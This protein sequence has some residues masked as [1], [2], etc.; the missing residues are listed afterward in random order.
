MAEDKQYINPDNPVYFSYAWANDEHPDIEEDVNNLCKLLEENHIYYKRDKD[1]LCPYRWSIQKSE[2]EIGEG[3][4][5]IVVIS[6]RYLKSLHCM[7][8][9]HLIRENGQIWK[10]VFPIVLGNLK[11]TD[12]DTFREYYKIF[13][14]RAQ[15]LIDQ[16][17]EDIIPLTRVETEAA[18]AG[19]YVN[20]L[21][22]MYQYLA[23]NNKLNQHELRKDNYAVIIGQLKDFLKETAPTITI[24]TPSVTP[25]DNSAKVFPVSIPD[26]LLPRDKEADKLYNGITENH[27]FNL[28]A[29]GGMGK[30][31]LAYLMVQR[32]KKD[33]NEIAYVVV[34]NNIK[35]AIV[36]QLNSALDLDF[37]DDK[38]K[39]Q[40][41]VT[42]LENNFKATQPNLLVLDINEISDET[43]DFIKNINKLSPKNW[44][45]LTL[46]R[47][48]LDTTEIMTTED[49]N[50]NQDIEFLKKLFLK[51]AGNRYEGFEK[52]PELFATIFYN[53]L[54]AEQLGFFLSKWPEPKSLEAIKEIL[55]ADTFKNKD[56]KGYAVL[57]NDNR[58]TVINFLTNLA[59]YDSFDHN[60]Q[61]LLRHFV[62]W[63]ADFIPYNVIK[64]LLQ[65]VFESDEILADTLSKL[66]DRSIFMVKSSEDGSFSYKLHGL[67]AESLRG[68]IDLSKENYPIY[69]LYVLDLLMN[70]NASDKGIIS[71]CIFNSARIWSEKM[72]ESDTY[73]GQYG[74]CMS[75]FMLAVEQE[76]NDAAKDNFK[77][78]IEIGE[79]LPKD[80][81]RY[82]DALAGAHFCFA[83]F[84]E[85]RLHDYDLAKENYEKA[86]AIREQLP[87]DNPEF[88][89]GLAG[90]YEYL[91][92]L[93]E[94]HFQDYD[95]AKENYEK[96]IAIRE[97]LPK[98][99]SEYQNDLANTYNNLAILQKNHF[100]AYDL[101][102]G[103]YEKAIAIR[104]QLPKDNPEYQN[105]LAE[106]YRNLAILQ[107]NH[108]QAFDLS[109]ENYEKAI[110]IRE[111]LSKKG[112]SEFQYELAGTY[113]NLAYIQKNHFQAYDLAKENYEKAIAIREQLSKKGQNE[114]LDSLADSYNNF[115]YLLHNDYFKD[116]KSAKEYCHKAIEITQQLSEKNPAKYL[117]DL[118]GRKHSLA[119]ICFDNNEIETAKA[120]LEEIKQPAAKCLAEN[121]NDNYT[122]KLNA[123][124]ADLLEKIKQSSPLSEH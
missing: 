50:K 64:E 112:D 120:I 16:Q 13:T 44:K 81:P 38:D 90:T 12:K 101:A 83:Y 36:A 122:K 68:Q 17:Q 110:A 70:C 49:F 76:D 80:N 104:E 118:L 59:S 93:Q 58:S 3:T 87:K 96:A 53:P 123:A 106:S 19:F 57:T 55:Y 63:P 95:T 103:N 62:L 54:L 42:Y 41:L 14:D 10:R 56:M 89:N 94:N 37:K 8:E 4:A 11:L 28:V 98:E 88:Q 27:F 71:L 30:S 45:V 119:E 39:Y 65:G 84:F 25:T 91:A 31:S 107:E 115:A 23:D 77:K 100:Q 78:A 109:K 21:K 75:L 6:E 18:N 66:A 97:Q 108:L 116:F 2:E 105:D 15:N 85:E 43:K 40:Q 111:Q 86:I 121:P 99:K 67:L 82:Q 60:E 69:G 35:D 46:S 20:D 29:L 33:F 9:W 72:S 61:E 74:Q 114:Y 102:K 1:N 92:I 7:N 51:R 5:I 48:N 22:R 124:I 73:R 24:A 79:K 113:H 34:N 26:N 52:F 47:E 117:I 32:H